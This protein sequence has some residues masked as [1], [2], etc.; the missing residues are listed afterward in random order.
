MRIWK[1][2]AAVNIVILV[3][4]VARCS[5]GEIE[6]KNMGSPIIGV[7][8]YA[9]ENSLAEL[10]SQWRMLGVNA[11]FVSVDLGKNQEFRKFAELDDVD[12]FII[13]P[14]FY[15]PE[16]LEKSPDLYAITDKG[17]KA[18]EEWVRFVCP[19]REDYRERRIAY[20]KQLV[21]ELRPDGISLDFI[22]FFVYWEKIYA[23]RSLNSIVQTCFDSH[24]LMK[25]QQESGV[26]I[27]AEISDVR[28]KARWILENRLQEWTEWKCHVITAMV[29]DIV[30]GVK[31]ID[32]DIMINVH[33]VPW[34]Q[35]DF[36][37]AI[38]IIAGQDLAKMAEH[39]DFISP[40]CYSHM[41]KRDPIWIQS[42]VADIYGQ[43]QSRILPSIQVKEAYLED[44]LSVDEFRECLDAALKTPSEGVVFWSWEALEQDPEKKIIIQETM[45]RFK[46]GGIQ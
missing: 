16:E 21:R 11:A 3:L 10:F 18:S 17:E 35:D 42:V 8:I 45:K 14:V 31:K 23:D 26:R 40:M 28:E 29:G 15:N 12:I 4:S 36:R 20:I 39:T 9:Y 7:K 33:A 24:C 22:R 46:I 1:S 44:V 32:P 19:T 2:S 43:T 13:L 34:R 27:P 30:S 41:L 5:P 25:F 6:Q 38:R 37:G